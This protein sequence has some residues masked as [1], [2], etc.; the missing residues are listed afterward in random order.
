MELEL[1]T[2]QGRPIKFTP[3][4]MEQIRNLLERGLS[5]EQIAEMVG[6][7][8]GSLAVTCSRAGVSLRQIRMSS[9]DKPKNNGGKTPRSPSRVT[10]IESKFALNIVVEY[11]GQTRT[12]VVPLDSNGMLKLILEATLVDLAIGDYVADM[13][14]KY[15]KT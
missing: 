1:A 12:T 3:E 4:R 6:T 5:R 15:A 2:A 9:I 7:T 11:K 8:V 13:I 10:T 14:S